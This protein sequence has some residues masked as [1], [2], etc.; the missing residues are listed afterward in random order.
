MLRDF[1]HLSYEFVQL[2]YNSRT[3]LYCSCALIARHSQHLSDMCPSSKL[4]FILYVF[5][6]AAIQFRTTAVQICMAASDLNI[7]Q[8]DGKKNGHVEILLATLR[9][10][11]SVANSYNSCTISYE[12]LVFPIARD[13]KAAIRLK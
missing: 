1:V 6:T 7:S 13:R 11:V 5:R 2:S 8:A 12:F 4:L 3:N 9:S 10:I